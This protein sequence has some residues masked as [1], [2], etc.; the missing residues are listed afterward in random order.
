MQHSNESTNVR[1]KDSFFMLQMQYEISFLCEMTFQLLFSLHVLN[2][3]VASDLLLPG[4]L[5]LTVCWQF[6]SFAQVWS[7]LRAEFCPA[8]SLHTTPLA[9]L[10]WTLHSSPR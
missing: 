8:S 7:A 10:S 2:S 4:W 6:L 9:G 3:Q 1:E 5:L